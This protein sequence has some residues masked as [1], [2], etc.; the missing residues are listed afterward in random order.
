MTSNTAASS[1]SGSRP[2]MTGMRANMS[3][4]FATGS[5]GSSRVEG[6]DVLIASP[7]LPARGALDWRAV[8]VRPLSQ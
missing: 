8:V 1:E 7:P 4:A 5:G 2:M 6:L 3:S